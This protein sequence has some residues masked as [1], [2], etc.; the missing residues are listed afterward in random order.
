[1]ETEIKP[2]QNQRCTIF[3]L[4]GLEFLNIHSLGSGNWSI[5]ITDKSS[6]IQS[7]FLLLQF[8]SR[9][10]CPSIWSSH[11]IFVGLGQVS[12]R[13][14]ESDRDHSDPGA[15]SHCQPG[16]HPSLK[17]NHCMKTRSQV[18]WA[19]ACTGGQKVD[20]E[21]HVLWKMND[22]DFDKSTGLVSDNTRDWM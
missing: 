15:P 8:I 12:E 9:I 19:R 11:R 17:L 21:Y 1:M 13:Y 4:D 5:R 10:S 20:G 2:S 6:L 22:N 7:R 3:H 16:G 14:H 18:T